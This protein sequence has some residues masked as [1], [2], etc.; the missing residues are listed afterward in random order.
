E[1]L[2]KTPPYE[3]LRFDPLKVPADLLEWFFFRLSCFSLF[4]RAIECFQLLGFPEPLDDAC[5]SYLW[6]AMR[7]GR[8]DA[9]EKMVKAHPRPEKMQESMTLGAKLILAEDDPAKLV[10]TL[11]EG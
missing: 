8:K 10:K 1:R 4:D 5:R 2:D 9:I 6:C 3:V 11:E 7:E